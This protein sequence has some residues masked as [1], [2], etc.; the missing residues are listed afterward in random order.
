MHVTP[1][2]QQQHERLY[3][4][5]GSSS[6]IPA[7]SHVNIID[8]GDAINQRTGDR[9]YMRNFIVCGAFE[10]AASASVGSRCARFCLIYDRRPTSVLPTVTQIFDTT[11]A[12]SFPTL[13]GRDRFEL[14][15]NRLVDFNKMALFQTSPTAGI[16]YSQADM[17]CFRL[18]IPVNRR[19]TYEPATVSGSLTSIVTGALYLC[20]LNDNPPSTTFNASIPFYCRLTYEDYV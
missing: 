16:V 8:Q 12:W 20:L 19:V 6:S 4:N 9:C 10:A 18:V 17:R 3:G 15:Y 11:S 14:L 1:F 5:D 13:I 7:M 2:A